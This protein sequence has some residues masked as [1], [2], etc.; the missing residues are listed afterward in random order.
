MNSN[1]RELLFENNILINNLINGKINMVTG[2]L[3]MFRINESAKRGIKLNARDGSILY[4][5]YLD[6]YE[7]EFYLNA[8]V[9]NISGEEKEIHFGYNDYDCVDNIN[10]S[11]YDIIKYI[12]ANLH[13]DYYR[14]LRMFYGIGFKRV[15]SVN[16]IAN[17][18]NI[19]CKNV[20]LIINEGIDC[21]INAFINADDKKLI[22]E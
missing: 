21:I 12:Q 5:Y 16:E 18:L 6:I 10:V 20:R 22:L 15:Y 2:S 13:P 4:D 9:T 3:V 14:I 7:N 17:I 8:K 19:T 11:I 1:L